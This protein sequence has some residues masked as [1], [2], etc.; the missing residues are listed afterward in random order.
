M[1]RTRIALT[2]FVFLFV[3][4]PM[5]ASAQADTRNEEL[6]SVGPNPL[7]FHAIDRT[8]FALAKGDEAKLSPEEQILVNHATYMGK[9][10]GDNNRILIIRV[11]ATVH[12]PDLSKVKDGERADFWTET[13]YRGVAVVAGEIR[14]LVYR[15]VVNGVPGAR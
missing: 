1:T 9:V 5:A 12:Y 13:A 14:V 6:D 8:G 11:D 4:V 10:P 15:D 3:L 7:L 2:T